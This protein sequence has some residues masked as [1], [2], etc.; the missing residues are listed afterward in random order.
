MMLGTLGTLLKPVPRDLYLAM[1]SAAKPP[2]R[3]KGDRLLFIINTYAA[4][5]PMGSRNEQQPP[6]VEQK[7]RPCPKEL[8][9]A[10]VWDGRCPR[11][12][13]GD[14]G[15]DVAAMLPRTMQSSPLPQPAQGYPVQFGQRAEGELLEAFLKM[16]LYCHY[17]A[18]SSLS[19]PVQRAA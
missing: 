19:S 3:G 5:T 12:S 9:I 7:A 13:L 15:R 18:F 1:S 16:W 6:C 2:N 14:A 10:Y 11:G 8:V 17:Q 4:A